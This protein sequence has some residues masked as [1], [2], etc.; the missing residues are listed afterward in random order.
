MDDVGH[1]LEEASIAAFQ[2]SFTHVLGTLETKA[3]SRWPARTT[4]KSAP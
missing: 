1:T 2:A 4:A 3:T